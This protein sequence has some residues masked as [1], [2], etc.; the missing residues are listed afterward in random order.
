M[1]ELVCNGCDNVFAAIL[2]RTQGNYALRHYLCSQ[3]EGPGMKSV[4]LTT[5]TSGHVAV[6]ELKQ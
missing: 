1:T 2:V 6:N 3:Q 5:K 4:D